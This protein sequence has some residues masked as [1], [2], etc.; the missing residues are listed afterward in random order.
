MYVIFYIIPN[1]RVII[2]IRYIVKYV[3]NLFIVNRTTRELLYLV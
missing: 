2:N 3:C 1:Y